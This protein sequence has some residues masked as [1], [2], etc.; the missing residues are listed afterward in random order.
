[1]EKEVLVEILYNREGALAWD[2]TELRRISHE[3]APPQKI[4]IIP[5][6]PW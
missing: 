2:W 1:M 4:K 3:V 6:K 5:H